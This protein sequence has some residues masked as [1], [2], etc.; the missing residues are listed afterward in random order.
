[1][2]LLEMIDS[3]RPS[4]YSYMSVNDFNDALDR[5]AEAVKKETLCTGPNCGKPNASRLMK[6]WTDDCKPDYKTEVLWVF[7][8][9]KG[10]MVKAKVVSY[11]D[12]IIM[13]EGRAFV[14]IL[15]IT[16]W[17]ELEPEPTPTLP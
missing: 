8:T 10:R 6:R 5:I 3:E 12:I 11:R 14:G 9:I 15:Q 13:P 2:T 17:L 7:G 1:M 16:H 4:I